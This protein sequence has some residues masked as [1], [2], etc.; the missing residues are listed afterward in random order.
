MPPSTDLAGA[1]TQSRGKREEMI[2]VLSAFAFHGFLAFYAER[3]PRNSLQAPLPDFLLTA[4]A[5]SEGLISDPLQGGLN[6]TAR[7]GCPPKVH[8]GNISLCLEQAL[9]YFVRTRLDGDSVSGLPLVGE[10]S[11]LAGKNSGE[12]LRLGG[13]HFLLTLLVRY[14][15]M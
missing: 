1:I 3:S 5:D 7:R 10:F 12:L 6:L 9:L 8:P 4:D 13:D 15:D 11:Q 14:F 2:H